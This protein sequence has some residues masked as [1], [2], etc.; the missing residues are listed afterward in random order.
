MGLVV[1]ET[2]NNLRI[3]LTWTS[4][5]KTNAV[6]NETCK[7]NNIEIYYNKI[8]GTYRTRDK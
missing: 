3:K 6:V 1:V 5:L 7:V 4:R 2:P 8:Q